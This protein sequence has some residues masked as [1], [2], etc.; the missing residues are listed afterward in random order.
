MTTK[1]KF[2]LSN[3]PYDKGKILSIH[4]CEAPGRNDDWKMFGLSDEEIIELRNL[5]GSNHCD[6]CPAISS[7]CC[8]DKPCEFSK[9]LSEEIDALSK[10]MQ[11]IRDHLYAVGRKGMK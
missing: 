1:H 6:G 5:L 11:R 3:N 8:G 4:S 7:F 2:S 10:E 9:G